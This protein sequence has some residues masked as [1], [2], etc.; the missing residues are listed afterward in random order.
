[1]S[2]RFEITEEEIEQFNK[3][4]PISEEEERKMD[5]M[6]D[7]IQWNAGKLDGVE[8]VI[9]EEKKEKPLHERIFGD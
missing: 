2:D 3:D 7:F 5:D 9:P 6:F 1:M 8:I 4:N